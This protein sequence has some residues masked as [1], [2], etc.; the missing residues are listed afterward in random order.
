MDRCAPSRENVSVHHLNRR[1][2]MAEQNSP[3]GPVGGA[4]L[5]NALF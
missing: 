2:L 1:R 4:G 3:F 5:Y